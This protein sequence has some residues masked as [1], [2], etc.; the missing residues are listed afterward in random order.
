VAAGTVTA[1]SEVAS[2]ADPAERP[3]VA[4]Y[5]HVPFCLSVCPYCDFVVL[6]GSAARGPASRIDAYLEAVVQELD[7]RADLLDARF[8]PPGTSGRQVLGTVYLGGGTP[9]LLAAEH[10]AGLIDRAARRLGLAHDPEITVEANPGRD[11]LGDLAGFRAAGVDRL[12]IGAQS[13]D[14]AELRRIGRRHSPA[15][16]D[17]AVRLA[18]KAG[19][20]S[21]SVDLLYDLPGQTMATW[22]RTLEH[23]LRLDPDHVSAYA[24]T[25]DDPDAEGLTGPLGDHL[26]VRPGAR[27]WRERARPE[28]DAD[29]A[30]DMY[31]LADE[32]LGEAGYRWYELSNWARPGHQSRHNLCYW[33]REPYLGLGPGAHSFDGGTERR[34]NAARLDA[35][36]TALVPPHG[37]GP[38]LP[39]GGRERLAKREIDAERA[40]LGL[41]L[42]AGVEPSL[43]GRADG[44]PDPLAWAAQNQLIERVADR[45]RLTPRGRLLSNELFTRIA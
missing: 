16:V 26:G 38:R 29:R 18:R 9:S 21:V 5:V 13:L 14:Q 34:W 8:G 42:A 20:R 28:Q 22:R 27:R 17:R 39:P 2:Q 32:L 6:A 15:D 41:R 40:I 33:L 11:E 12:S 23:A 35:Y 24:L 30:A 7:L 25:L 3:P 44:S 43:V 31:L 10:V 19:F 37:G 45:V 4:L 1:V 36:L